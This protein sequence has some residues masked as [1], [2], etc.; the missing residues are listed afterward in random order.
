VNTN[1]ALKLTGNSTGIGQTYRWESSTTLAGPYTPLGNVLF[2]PDTVIVATATFYYR[3]AV[4]CGAST[5]YSTPVQLVVNPALPAGTYT[6]DQTQPASATNFTSFN[7][8]KAAMSCGVVL[9]C[10]MWLR[11]P[12]HIMNN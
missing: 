8:A 2:N 4:T 1:V 6:I 12:V 7:A 9:W 3:V 11:L 5:T 10:S